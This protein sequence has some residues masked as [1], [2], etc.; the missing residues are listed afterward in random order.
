MEPATDQDGQRP[1]SGMRPRTVLF[2]RDF[3]ALS[4]GHLKVWHYFQHVAAL[5]GFRPRVYFAPGSRLDDA[6]P[7]LAAGVRP[8]PAWDPGPTDILFLGGMDWRGVDA[9]PARHAGRPVLNIIQGLRHADP[10]DPRH[11]FLRRPA[12]RLAV[13]PLIAEAIGRVPGVRGPVVCLPMGLD[14]SPLDGVAGPRAGVLIAALKNPT[15]GRQLAQRLEDDG[16]GVRLL[17]AALPRTQYL[18]EVAASA[19]LV[20][21][22]LP[23]EGFYLPA[24]EGMALGCLVICP[25]CG[26][27]RIYLR[28]DVN[29]LQPGWAVDDLR[30][31]VHAALA[32][33]PAAGER[34]RRQAGATAAAFSLQAERDALHAA[35]RD[36]DRLW[37]SCG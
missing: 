7:W 12:I 3:R 9:L 26:G 32:L 11:A 6:N 25:D 31:A 27:N 4:G 24:L 16:I 33:K 23:S 2:F 37:E 13:N 8:E 22:P 30:N 15:L 5:E 1:G 36:V 19:V 35:L 29:A 17:D 20:C 21:L 34:M 14:V 18:R 28:P 10:A